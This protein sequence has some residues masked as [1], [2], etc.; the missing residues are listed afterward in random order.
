MNLL[1]GFDKKMLPLCKID[2]KLFSVEARGKIGL[3]YFIKLKSIS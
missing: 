1:A 3:H 2:E